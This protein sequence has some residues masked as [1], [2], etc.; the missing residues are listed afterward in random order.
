MAFGRAASNNG[1]AAK[2]N[3][4]ALCSELDTFRENF[5]TFVSTLKDNASGGARA[6][7]DTPLPPLRR[8]RATLSLPSDPP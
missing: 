3:F 2:E 8:L 5:G 7:G 1:R 4:D 6:G